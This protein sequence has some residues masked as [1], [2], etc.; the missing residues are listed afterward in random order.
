MAW[1][2]RWD[3]RAETWPRPVRWLYLG[4]KWYLVAAGAIVL[5]VV[6]LQRMGILH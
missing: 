2:A 6:W 3:A 4:V 1:L 5:T